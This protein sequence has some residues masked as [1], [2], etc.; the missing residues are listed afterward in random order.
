[1]R[2]AEYS[3]ASHNYFEILRFTLDDEVK[4][5]FMKRVLKF[6]ILSL[7]LVF[8]QGVMA[9][10]L[11]SQ[12]YNP[13]VIPSVGEDNANYDPVIGSGVMMPGQSFS[14]LREGEGSWGTQ[15]V[16]TSSKDLTTCQNCCTGLLSQICPDVADCPSEY[17]TLYHD[18]ANECG[19]SLPLDGGIYLIIAL[20]VA[21]GAAKA[22]FIHKK[23]NIELTMQ[24]CNA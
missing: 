5:M 16:Q 23:N 10:T 1:M 15:C 13:Y 18:C 6:L 12:S 22:A 14:T 11:P 9:V 19:R 7:G 2:H 17:L 3:E 8:A 4:I 24:C 20:A 21:F